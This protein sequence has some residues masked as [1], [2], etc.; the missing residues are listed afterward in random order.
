MRKKEMKQKGIISA[1]FNFEDYVHCDSNLKVGDE[2]SDETIVQSTEEILGLASVLSD[3]EEEQKEPPLARVSRSQAN[4][5]IRQLRAYFQTKSND[6][7]WQLQKLIYIESDINSVQK[8]EQSKLSNFFKHH[9][10]KDL[11]D[12]SNFGPQSNKKECQK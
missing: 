12:V 4:D 9:G 6:T 3:E 1:D 7:S 11:L 10:K 5:C 2:L 8:L